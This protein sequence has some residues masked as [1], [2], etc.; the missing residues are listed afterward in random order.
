MLETFFLS[1]PS[2]KDEIVGIINEKKTTDNFFTLPAIYSVNP[3][4]WD[5]QQIYVCVT[6][7]QVN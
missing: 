3:L 5:N 4:V 7:V 6:L 1:I 2:Q